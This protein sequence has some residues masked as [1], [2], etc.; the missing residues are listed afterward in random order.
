[1]NSIRPVIL[2]E[3]DLLIRKGLSYFLESEGFIVK[4]AEN[5]KQG[6]ELIR[7]SG[8]N[9]LV[10]LDL[11]MPVMTGEELLEALSRDEDSTIRTVPV[12]VLTARGNGFQH[13]GIM[14]TICKPFD[15]DQVLDK[16]KT[17]C[18]T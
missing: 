18:G 15:L 16:V 3:D 2:V 13:L 4:E 6:L 11:Q 14:G 7:E 12:L 5:G 8:G 1:M 9:C 10:L 17:L